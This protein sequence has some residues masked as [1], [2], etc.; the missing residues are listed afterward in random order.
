MKNKNI[1]S[2]KSSQWRLTT[3]NKIEMTNQ[4]SVMILSQISCMSLLSMYQ[5]PTTALWSMLDTY[6]KGTYRFLHRV[7]KKH[8]RSHVHQ[9]MDCWFWNLLIV[10]HISMNLNGLW[11][12]NKYQLVSR[13][14]WKL[15]IRDA[16]E[17]AI[18]ATWW[19]NHTGSHSGP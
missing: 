10:L 15:V 12:G 5:A 2:Y 1:T 4:V 8:T 17:V 9:S 16:R 19:R 6:S 18:S 14:G 7:E 13:G 11:E 3:R